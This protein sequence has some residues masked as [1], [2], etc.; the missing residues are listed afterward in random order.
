MP[1][2]E[3]IGRKV[4]AK[5]ELRSGWAAIPAGTILTI[6][7]KQGGLGLVSDPCSTCGVSLSITK[8]Q[9]Q[10]VELLT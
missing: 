1:A 6:R 2:R 4:R 5:Q 10:Y 3:M 9:P 7:S 8:V